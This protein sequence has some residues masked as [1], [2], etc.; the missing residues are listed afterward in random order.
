MSR[1]DALLVL[2]VL[3]WGVNYSVL[4]RA[5]LD[6]PP[7]PF[8]A[9]RI[10]IAAGL[11]L[12]AIRRVRRRGATGPVSSVFYT[13]HALTS[14]DRWDLVWLGLVGHCAY[15]F[16][17][18]S[19]V[20]QT[21]VSNAALIIGATPVSVAVLSAVVARERIGVL[22]W[23]GA[24][25]SVLGI[26]VVVG[27][28]AS[29]G[30][31]TFAGDCLVML[32]VLCWSAYTIGA[33]RLVRRH[34]ALYVTGMTM[35][36]GGGPY[37]LLALPGLVALDWA[38]PAWWIW[39]AL[40][41]SA[42]FALGVAYLIWYAAVQRIGATRTAIYSNVVPIVAMAVAALWLGEPVTRAKLLGAAAILGGVLLTRARQ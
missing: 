40:V 14:R 13:P 38:R 5:F 23:L 33:G 21:S 24:G 39:V 30:G 7:Q 20:D 27:R 17:F 16:C 19:G 10:S 12:W 32:S 1:I 8:N 18:V 35:A 28:G 26:Y 15:Q 2:M 25:V 36:I 42:L 4:K 3:I 37:V 9:L 31:A 6:I 41:L 34:S 29:F 22:H 11:F